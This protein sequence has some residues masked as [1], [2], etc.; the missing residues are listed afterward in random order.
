MAREAWDGGDEYVS[1]LGIG[2]CQILLGGL[3]GILGL[4]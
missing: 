3:E 2:C 1:A 4:F